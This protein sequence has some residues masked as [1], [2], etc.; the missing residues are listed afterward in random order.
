MNTHFDIL[1][2]ASGSMGYFKDKDGNPDLNYL[3]SDGITTRTELVKHILIN[4]IIPKLSYIDSIKISTFSSPL[5]LNQFG[6]PLLK[7]GNKQYL[8]KFGEIFYGKYNLENIN[9]SINEIKIPSEAGTPL[10]WAT[11]VIIN[12]S[13]QENIN[14]II[15][16]D[17]DDSV[18]KK[19]DEI[20]LKT[21]GSKKCKIYFIGIAQNDEAATKSKKIAVNTGGKYVNIDTISYN[22][23]VFENFLF[24]IN[25]TITS[26]AL[27]E[28]LKI[29]PSI[30]ENISEKKIEVEKEL[31]TI[32]EV[33]SQEINEK[34]VEH[35]DIKRQVVENTKSLQ[36]ISS[37]LDTIVK[38]ISF[39][40][41]NKSKEEDEFVDNEDEEFNK[42]VG[43]KTER[44]LFDVL[45]SKWK[46]TTWLNENGEQGK[47]Y[48]FEVLFEGQTYYM[49][50]KGTIKNIKEFFL[51][52]NEWLFYLANRKYYRLYF[53]S[54]INSQN[55]TIHRIEDLLK[56]MEEGKL[57]SCSSINRKVKTDRILFQII[58]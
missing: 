56:D 8:P 31:D 29:Q 13:K 41:N 17:G 15:I 35:S 12:Q 42:L 20:I 26:N 27:K 43:N 40:G 48:D 50:C 30:V 18:T 55:P 49:E 53:V 52:K 11:C 5:V 9:S 25:T 10:S 37:Q 16:S 22:K 2:D 46:D 34:V 39:I 23:L 19:Y 14:I 32:E 7:A 36:L 51:T 47:P 33:K 4:S 58:D 38:Q 57:I 44:I 45:K 1:I 6:N 54:E 24:D 3:L 21:I 28:N